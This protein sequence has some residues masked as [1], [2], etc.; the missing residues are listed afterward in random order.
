MTTKNLSIL[1]EK[2]SLNEVKSEVKHSYYSE[3]LKYRISEDIKLND[4]ELINC[5]KKKDKFLIKKI[6]SLRKEKLTEEEYKEFST[7]KILEDLMT[8]PMLRVMLRKDPT[9]QSVHENTQ[10]EWIKKNKYEDVIKL[11]SSNNGVYLY[12]NSLCKEKERNTNATKTLDIYSR[13]EN[14][15]G[16][17]KYTNIEGGSQD[18]QYNDVKKFIIEIIGYFNNNL[19]AVERFE[20]YLDGKYYDKRR[21]ILEKMIPPN[22]INKII[23]TSCESILPK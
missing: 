3:F 13:S 16:I 5:A 9:K 7:D 6:E 10:I 12:N 21:S 11:P 23:I 22:H 15:Y 20:F 2:L 14:M 19:E 4:K 1:L 17:L 8:N 18:N